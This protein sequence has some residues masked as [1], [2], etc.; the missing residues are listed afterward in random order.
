MDRIVDE[1]TGQAD[2]TVAKMQT[3]NEEAEDRISGH[4]N[5]IIDKLQTTDEVDDEDEDAQSDTSNASLVQLQAAAP[6][7][8]DL[9]MGLFRG[10]WRG[11]RKQPINLNGPFSLLNGPFS[12][13]NEPFP[14]VP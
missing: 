1:I 13:L 3:A 4:A 5:D 12:D 14:R 8:I 10:A 7:F 2:A 6:H 9:L 11:A